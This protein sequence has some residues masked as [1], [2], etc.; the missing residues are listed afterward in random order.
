MCFTPPP[1]KVWSV[2]Q[3]NFLFFIWFNIE[4]KESITKRNQLSVLPR[5]GTAEIT[6]VQCM[7]L[8]V[9]LSYL[10][11]TSPPS[12]ILKEPSSFLILIKNE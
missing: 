3:M 12:C 8:A 6:V 2:Q 5:S 7:I 9:N 10:T 1:Q 11:S 4:L